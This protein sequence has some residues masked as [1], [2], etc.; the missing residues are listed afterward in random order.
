MTWQVG[1]P[2]KYHNPRLGYQ[3]KHTKKTLAVFI[4]TS[5]TWEG[6]KFSTMGLGWLQVPVW[7]S[8]KEVRERAQQRTREPRADAVRTGT[9]NTDCSKAAGGQALPG[10]NG[11]ETGNAKPSD[12]VY[13]CPFCQG[14][15]KSSVTDG[16]V[17]H[18]NVCGRRFK[19][20]NGQITA[21]SNEVPRIMYNHVYM[22]VL[23]AASAESRNLWADRP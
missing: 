21:R 4:G 15:I 19:V 12:K 11:V 10:S 7:H 20:C 3:G 16:F 17:N 9:K 23:Q 6:Q 22:P 13:T 1:G 18:R 8:K 5:S 14:K 2:R